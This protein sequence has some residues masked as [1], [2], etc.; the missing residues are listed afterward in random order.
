MGGSQG[1]LR[2]LSIVLTH[3]YHFLHDSEIKHTNTACCKM[4]QNP[5]NERIGCIQLSCRLSLL[6]A[7]GHFLHRELQ[8]EGGLKGQSNG[9]EEVVI[10]S[11][12]HHCGATAASGSNY[13]ITHSLASIVH[14]L[15]AKESHPEN[16]KQNTST[17]R[18]FK[19][20]W[21]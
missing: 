6:R 15:S 9:R 13:V 1:K 17:G 5:F 11:T 12:Y 10:S 18:K 8:F 21:L 14:L 16:K 3:H 2:C 19:A 4:A 7:N 20:Y